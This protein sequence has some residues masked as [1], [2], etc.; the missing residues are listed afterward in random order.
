MVKIV[1]SKRVKH[2]CIED[3]VVYLYMINVDGSL[4]ILYLE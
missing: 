1:I 4:V 3:I 2:K